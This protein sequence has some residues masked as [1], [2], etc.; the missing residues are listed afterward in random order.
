MSAG[1]FF[2]RQAGARAAIGC[3][4]RRISAASSSS[5]RRR[6][7]ASRWIRSA[8]LW[9]R[10]ESGAAAGPGH[11]CCESWMSGSRRR[12]GRSRRSAVCG[13]RSSGV[14]GRWSGVLPPIMASATARALP[15][16]G[17]WFG[18][19]RYSR[20]GGSGSSRPRAPE[21]ERPRH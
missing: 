6:R 2:P 13:T 4:R 7:L 16:A 1:G 19:S 15:T 10:R 17:R 14:G 8:S 5:S 21:G 3:T 12:H 9:R 18:R 20:G 11:C